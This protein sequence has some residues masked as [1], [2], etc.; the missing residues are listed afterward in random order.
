MNN[1]SMIH[2]SERLFVRSCLETAPEGRPAGRQN[3]G[4]SGSRH[5]SARLHLLKQKL[6]HAAMAHTTDPRIHKQLCGAANTA[7]ELVWNTPNPLL[8]YPCLFEEMAQAILDR[9][10][11]E[12]WDAAPY[13]AL[14]AEP[15]V[16]PQYA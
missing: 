4:A 8:L 6:L 9:A 11:L 7:A 5:G 16:E 3:L 14:D 12:Q 2:D 1:A 13:F 15:M 10:S